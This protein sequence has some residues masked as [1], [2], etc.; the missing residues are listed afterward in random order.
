MLN[1]FELKKIVYCLHSLLYSGFIILKV[2]YVFM[3]NFANIINF[4]CQFRRVCGNYLF[5]VIQHTNLTT[6]HTW[7]CIADSRCFS[8]H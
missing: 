4:H 1:I 3:I 7:R 2:T 8:S 5:D 6:A